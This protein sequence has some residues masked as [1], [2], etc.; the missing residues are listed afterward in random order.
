[1]RSRPN[2][3]RNALTGGV[4]TRRLRR[5]IRASGGS[6][7]NAAMKG[8]MTSGAMPPETKTERQ[9]AAAVTRMMRLATAPPSGIPMYIV[10]ML[11]LRLAPTLVSAA[12]ATRFGSAP[13]RPSPVSSRAI[14]S[15]CMSQANI[16]KSEKSPNAPMAAISTFLRPIR[17]ASQP[18]ITAPMDSPKVLALKNRPF[19]P[20][21]GMNSRLRP[22]AA[23]PAACRSSPSQRAT[24]KQNKRVRRAAAAF[25]CSGNGAEGDRTLDLRIANATLSQLS[26]RP[27]Q[28]ARF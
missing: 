22:P 20:A 4:F 3:S 8:T 18:P 17:S 27:T 21:V 10:A 13:P 11:A 16:V 5:A 12:T 25:A 9:F 15:D 26:Y 23:T 6:G 7:M 19:W 24:R 14:V 28:G 2:S 1:M